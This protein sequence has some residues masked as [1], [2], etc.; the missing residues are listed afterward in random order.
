M[1]EGLDVA[2]A[3]K[4]LRGSRT[5][6]QCA[7]LAG[8][9]VTTW[10]KLERNRSSLTKRNFDQFAKG[11]QVSRLELQEAIVEEW[12]Q[13][14]ARTEALHKV[15]S[16]AEGRPGP[17]D[18]AGPGSEA[19]GPLFEA[20]RGMLTIYLRERQRERE[21]RA[22]LLQLLRRLVELLAPRQTPP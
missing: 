19:W 22:E 18:G 14:L 10:S 6:I 5:Q 2:S 15:D 21:E 3:I 20:C 13:R 16:L 8:L 17:V 11:L 1:L 7:E 12:R 9:H 4:K